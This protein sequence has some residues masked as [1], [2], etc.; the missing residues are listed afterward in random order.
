[1]TVGAC[2]PP[3]AARISPT[4]SGWRSPGTTSHSPPAARTNSQTHS[5]A[6]RTSSACAGSALTL[7][8]RR[9]SKSSSSQTA[10]GSATRRESSD[11]SAALRHLA[12][13]LSLREGLKLLEAV[14]LDLADALARDVED[15]PHF[16]QR[17]RLLA[18]QPVAHLED[19]PL[20]VRER[21]EHLLQGLVSH[22][23]ARLLI[24]KRRALVGDVVAELGLLL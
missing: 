14:V 19:A 17:P 3:F 22:R 20:A 2:P 6:R 5:P 15:P 8:M 21:R 13:L 11:G 12:E 18:V 4:A 23:H 16:V 24:G 7:G 9:N 10:S 1:M